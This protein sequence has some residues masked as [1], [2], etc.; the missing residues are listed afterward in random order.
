MKHEAY[1]DLLDYVC[2]SENTTKKYL[3]SAKALCIKWTSAH[4]R[5]RIIYKQKS[6]F[7]IN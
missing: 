1:Q 3:S 4:D 7:D 2:V 5:F 6:T